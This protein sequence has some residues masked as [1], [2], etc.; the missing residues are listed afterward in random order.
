MGSFGDLQDLIVVAGHATFGNDVATVPAQPD[1]DQWWILNASFQ[2]GEPPFYIE[3][4][5]R[6]VVLV[7]HNPAALLLFSGGLTRADTKWS[8]A[9]TYYELAKQSQCWIPDQYNEN[10]IR[11]RILQR[12]EKE[13]F[14][15]DSYENLLY[16][17]CRFHQLTHRFPRFVTVVSW[18]FK[19]ARFDLH[20][21]AIQFPRARF[22]FDGFNEPIDLDGAWRGERSAIHS[23]LEFPHGT[24]H[25]ADP[26]RD[27]LQKRID[28]TF[29]P[30]DHGYE[31]C[32]KLNEFIRVLESLEPSRPE[33]PKG[34]M[35]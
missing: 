31:Q 26:K 8:E 2:L 12:T 25:G 9:E 21:A 34:V 29:P 3:H 28:R 5:R 33:F 1:L 15:R 17:I 35:W 27:L 32:P 6:G 18:A 10:N 14:A 20:R 16:S 13:R 4:I 22:R 19:A 23:F 30:R 7:A 24:D 11:E